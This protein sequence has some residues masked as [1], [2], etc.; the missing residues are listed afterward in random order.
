MKTIELSDVEQYNLIYQIYIKQMY[1]LTETEDNPE[2]KKL[3]E[4]SKS[5]QENII[6]NIKLFQNFLYCKYNISFDFNVLEE[7]LDLEDDLESI[8]DF[9]KTLK[10][11]YNIDVK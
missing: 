5:L 2:Y 8:D 1:F 6:F 11:C 7:N 4:N 9:I 3:I 10:K